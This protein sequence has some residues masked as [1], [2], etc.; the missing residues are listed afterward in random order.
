MFLSSQ[1]CVSSCGNVNKH[2]YFNLSWAKLH[3]I[4]VEILVPFVMRARCLIKYHKDMEQLNDC[5][6]S[7]IVSRSTVM[8]GFYFEQKSKW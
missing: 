8:L 2:L 5:S 1:N 7:Y 4:D 6:S 3:A